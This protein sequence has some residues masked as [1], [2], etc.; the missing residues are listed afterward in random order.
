MICYLGRDDI[1]LNE[2]S[3]RRLNV[4]DR[5]GCRDTGLAMKPRSYGKRCLFYELSGRRRWWDVFGRR[6]AMFPGLWWRNMASGFHPLVD[7]IRFLLGIVQTRPSH[8]YRAV[9]TVEVVTLS[10]SSSRSMNL[11]N[12]SRACVRSSFRPRS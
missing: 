4:Q 7:T 9:R 3:R 8:R 5:A 12:A 6:R 2:I 1:H 11:S 10:L